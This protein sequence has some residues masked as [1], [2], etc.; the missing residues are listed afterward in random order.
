[1]IDDAKI[2]EVLQ[3]ASHQVI[4][5][6][7]GPDEVEDKVH[8]TLTELVENP[9]T[10]RD[11]RVWDDL[12]IMCYLVHEE[13]GL[14]VDDSLALLKRKHAAYGAESLTVPGPIGVVVRMLD[15]TCRR[16]SLRRQA[17]GGDLDD[18]TLGESLTDT[19]RDLFNYALLGALLVRGGIT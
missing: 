10:V 18:L 7:L 2:Y 16:R 17:L 19:L 13:H 14:S 9:E 4:P 3:H 8:Q 6:G 15:K 1:M 11:L 12:V 5:E